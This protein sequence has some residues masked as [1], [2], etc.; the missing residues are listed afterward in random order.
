VCS[1]TG[2]FHEGSQLIVALDIRQWLNLVCN[3]IL[4]MMNVIE[5]K[6]LAQIEVLSGGEGEGPAVRRKKSLFWR[7]LDGSHKRTAAAASPQSVTSG[8]NGGQKNNA[9]G[10]QGQEKEEEEEVPAKTELKEEKEEEEEEEK[11]QVRHLTEVDDDLAD[12]ALGG[13]LEIL[14]VRG[15][16]GSMD[17]H[18]MWVQKKPSVLRAAST[19]TLGHEEGLKPSR[20][21]LSSQGVFIIDC[22]SEIYVYRYYIHHRS[23]CPSRSAL[24]PWP[25][26]VCRVCVV[27]VVCVLCFVWK[28]G[29]SRRLT[30]DK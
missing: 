2:A 7:Y 6:S 26:I 12:E 8:G 25:H 19:T 1:P 14:E 13:I 29:A 17:L 24:S 22:T 10:N 28:V 16:Y 9:A 15:E 27:C 11:N 23:P 18:T 4:L 3:E 20:K 30:R 21:I 5:R